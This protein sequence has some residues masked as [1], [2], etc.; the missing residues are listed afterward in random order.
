MIDGDPWIGIKFSP[1]LQDVLFYAKKDAKILEAGCGL[2]HW[3]I[4]LSSLGYDM[5]GLDFSEATINRLRSLFPKNKFVVGDVTKFEFE[6]LAFDII[7]SWGV[8]EHFS[9]GPSVALKEAHRLLKNGG[10]L[11]VTVP[12]KNILFRLLT[13]VIGA[14]T[15][16]YRKVKIAF[17]KKSKKASF[18]QHAF[19]KSEFQKYV[20]DA[21][22]DLVRT[23]PI[24]HE[25]GFAKQMNS[26]FRISKK[27]LDLFHK[28]K[29]GKWQGITP[30]GR[31]IASLLKKINQWLTPDQIYVIARKL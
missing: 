12:C 30:S 27:K 3:V 21:G 6:D 5:T 24:S 16:I 8:M 14:K 25:V 31:I 17:G 18:Y 9:D 26:L 15:A 13:P 10:I 11:F 23:S 22:F 1:L 7:L 4:Y 29:G 19:R 2:G 20:A 28:N